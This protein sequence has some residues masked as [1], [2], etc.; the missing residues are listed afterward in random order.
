MPCYGPVKF[1]KQWS[2]LQQKVFFCQSDGQGIQNTE[3]LN[4]HKKAKN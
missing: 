1:H 4:Q 3:S 2:N